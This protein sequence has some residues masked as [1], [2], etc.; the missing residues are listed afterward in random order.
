[1]WKIFI[2]DDNDNKDDDDD[3]LLL[4]LYCGFSSNVDISNLKR[5]HSDVDV[6]VVDVVDFYLLVV[7]THI[8]INFGIRFLTVTFIA[9]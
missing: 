4:M 7:N 2:D 3:E 6:D 9:I 5:Q 1:M 8:T